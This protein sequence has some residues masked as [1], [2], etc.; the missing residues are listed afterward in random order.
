MVSASIC[1]EKEYPANE[2]VHCELCKADSV[3][4]MLQRKFCK[5]SSTKKIAQKKFCKEKF[6]IQNSCM[7]ILHSDFCPYTLG[8]DATRERGLAAIPSP[9]NHRCGSRHDGSSSQLTGFLVS[10]TCTDRI[11]CTASVFAPHSH[12]VGRYVG[13]SVGWKGRSRWRSG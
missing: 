2:I 8:G 11:G 1:F 13:R 7:Q 4:Q 3:N 9:Q 12:V 10:L 6:C 5:A